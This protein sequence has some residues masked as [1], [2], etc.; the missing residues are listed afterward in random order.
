MSIIYRKRWELI[1]LIKH[2]R[3]PRMYID[4]AAKYLKMSSS[5]AIG[6]INQYEAYGNVDFSDSKGGKTAT[7]EKQNQEMVKIA[8]SQKPMSTQQIAN[9]MANKGV[10][11]SRVTVSRRLK[12]HGLRFKPLVKKPLLNKTHIENRLIWATENVDWD[13]ARVIFSDE[14]RF[15]LSFGATRAWQFSG[16]PKVVRMSKHPPSINVWGCFSARGFGKLIIVRGILESNQIVEIY[17]KGLLPSASKFNRTKNQ[18]WYLLEDN[19]LKHTSNVCKK[20]KAEHRV[21]V[22]DW[23]AS[24]PECNSIENVWH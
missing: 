22:I 13:W 3:G 16:N 19:D 12:D 18:D 24:S 17:I 9:S 21:K 14:S 8:T 20:L 7:T 5:W 10:I 6:I 2:T 23:P 4:S 11:V 1:F 15:E